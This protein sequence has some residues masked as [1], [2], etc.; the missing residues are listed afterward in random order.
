MRT[1]SAGTRHLEAA[2]DSQLEKDNLEQIMRDETTPKG[3]A[4]HD[5]GREK[6]LADDP[7]DTNKTTDS[8]GENGVNRFDPAR[9][10]FA[11]DYVASVGVKKLLRTV[12]VRKPQ[13]QEWVRV[14]SDEDYRILVALLELKAEREVY[15]VMPAVA[16]ELGDEVSARMV[17]T[18]ISRQ[19]VVF[20]W[21]VR[22]PGPDGRIDNWSRS[23]LDAADLAMGRWLRVVANMDLGAYEPY[24][25][26]ASIPDPT[27]PD[28]S[29]AELLKLAFAD[30]YIDTIDHPVLARLRGER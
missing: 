8:G 7:A 19:G 30:K 27:W 20:L 26:S 5:A 2:A 1:R 16:A 12:P 18:A 11:T 15:L 24:E 23:A 25:S 17:F 4:P 22:V 3:T 9:L 13:R 10:R 21:P 6:T 28:L 14:H 29:L